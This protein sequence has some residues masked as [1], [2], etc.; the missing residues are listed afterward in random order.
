M[1][2]CWGGA[3][4]AWCQRRC[5][6]DGMILWSSYLKYNGHFVFH[7]FLPEPVQMESV[8]DLLVFVAVTV[9]KVTP[10]QLT[11]LMLSKLLAQDTVE[12]LV[13]K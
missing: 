2:S 4:L 6:T 13:Y 12:A 9:Y 8:L 1:E 5:H 3:W 11:S 10:L 7:F